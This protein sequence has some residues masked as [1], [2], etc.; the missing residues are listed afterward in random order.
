MAALAGISSSMA[1]LLV[2]ELVLV[3]FGCCSATLSKLKKSPP[4]TVNIPDSLQH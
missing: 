4:L 3:W 1:E 2:N